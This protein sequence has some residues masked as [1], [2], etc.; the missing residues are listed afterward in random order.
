MFQNI[1]FFTFS[2]TLKMCR[3]F[4]DENLSDFDFRKEDDFIL[5]ENKPNQQLV[6][7]QKKNSRITAKAYFFEKSLLGKTARGSKEDFKK[8]GG[9]IKPIP[10]PVF[11]F[12]F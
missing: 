9:E 8:K 2:T 1:L 6:L 5:I 4:A 11:A 12:M 7:E 10:N 3:I